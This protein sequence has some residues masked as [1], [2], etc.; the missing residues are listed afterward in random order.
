MATRLPLPRWEVWP[1]ANAD[2][3]RTLAI[4]VPPVARVRALV[5]VPAAE[6]TKLLRPVLTTDDLRGTLGVI[7]SHESMIPLMRRRDRRHQRAR[8]TLRCYTFICEEPFRRGSAQAL[9]R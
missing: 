5:V 8:T 1:T 7:S 2:P 9:F 6:A 4:V 3:V